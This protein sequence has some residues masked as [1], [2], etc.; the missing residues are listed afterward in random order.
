MAPFNRNRVK[1]SVKKDKPKRSSPIS[2]RTRRF[3]NL[4]DQAASWYDNLV[5]DQGS[6]YQKEVLMPG[7]WRLLGLKK[8]DSVLDLACGQG[9]F[10]RFLNE[11]G[12]QV[13]GLDISDE[14]IH[15][16]KGRSSQEIIYWVADATKRT[17]LEG[18]EFDAVVC[19]L[20]VQNMVDIGAVFINVSRWLKP[21]G[22]FVFIVTHPCF[23]IP[24]QTH[25]GWDED[26][27]IQFRRVDHYAT[28]VNIPI[29]TPPMAVSNKFTLTY[30]RSLQEYFKKL[31]SAG[32]WVDALEEWSSHKKSRPGGRSRAENRAR[33]EIPLFLAIRARLSEN[34]D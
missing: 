25:W 7:A 26:K 21:E 23:R 18:K 1:K 3:S 19:L 8:R 14:L 12:I 22:K 24:R 11:R 13:E 33:K 6:E 31:S 29:L 4:W 10:S 9:V 20:A 17:S 34:R 30:H 27:K 28:A 5:G 15:Y 2:S 16:A 32:L